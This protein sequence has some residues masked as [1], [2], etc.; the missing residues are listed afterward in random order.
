[1]RTAALALAA[2]LLAS[3]TPRAVIPDSERARVDAALDG[4]RRWLRVAAFA[5]P[6]FGDRSKVLVTE[7][8]LDA[9][10]LVETPG[11][12]PVPPPP[13]EKVIAPGTVVRVRQVEFPTPWVIA[14]RVVNSPRYHPWVLLDIAGD[15]RPHVIVLEQTAASFDEVRAEVDRLLAP[16]DGPAAAFAALPQEQKD[17]V[18][19]KE[20]VEGMSTRA[21]EMAWG[22]PEKKRI[23]RPAG[24][25]EWAWPDGKRR[26][27]FQDDRLVKSTR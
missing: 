23:D 4:Q 19:R 20:V 22:L 27:S 13:A 12:K 24:T 9:L 6:L 10:D 5:V 3:C 7:Q 2:V 1:M 17:A 8:P 14:Q 21:V 25:E 26:A 16:D 18:M 15:A 11:G